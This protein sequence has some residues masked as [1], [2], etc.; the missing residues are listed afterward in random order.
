MVVYSIVL[1]QPEVLESCGRKMRW[2]NEAE[3][4]LMSVK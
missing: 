4:T 2:K 3:V 1:A